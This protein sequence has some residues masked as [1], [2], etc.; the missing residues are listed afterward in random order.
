MRLIQT[1]DVPRPEFQEQPRRSF[2]SRLFWKITTFSLLLFTGF[3]FLKAGTGLFSH[4]SAVSLT[5][6]EAAVPARITQ[7]RLQTTPIQQM[8]PG[9]RVLGRNPDRWDTQPVIEPE[10]VSWRLV[11]VRMEQQPGKFVLGQ[12][13]RPTSWI[14]QNNVLLG[15]V[16]Q[17]EIPEMHVAGDAE[18]LSIAD[19]PP[20]RRGAGSVVTG[21]FRHVSD[22]VISVFVEGEAEPIGA[23]SQHPFW[24]RDRD[25]FIPAGELRIGEELKTALGT[26][27]RVTSIEI[28]AGPET[29]Y[30]LEVAGEHVYQITNAGLLVHNASVRSGGNAPTSGT[31]PQGIRSYVRDIEVQTGRKLHSRQ[32]ELLKDNLRSQRYSKLSKADTARHRRQFDSVKDDLIAEWER[33]TGQSWPRYTENLPKKNGKPGF[34]RLKGDPYDA[35]HVIENELGGPAEWW[36]IHPA[37]FPGQHQGGIHRSGSPLRQ[38]LEN[39]D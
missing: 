26:S 28:R 21:T 6:V 3:C 30:G 34:S 20:I 13:L 4:D 37:R 15:A 23:T 9:M 12:L 19:C 36:N 16:I 27:T 25:A 29:V 5:E 18:V 24:S 33:Q 38:L 31:L 10:P 8:R 14:S 2:A 11:S 7:Q 39:I 1:A 35:H 17:L 32:V 22:E